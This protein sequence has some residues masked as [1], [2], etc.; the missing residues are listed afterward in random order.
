MR[1]QRHR[2]RYAYLNSAEVEA[3]AL[4]MLGKS[5]AVI[6]KV[7]GLSK[8]QISYRL[9]KAKNAD[10][11]PRGQGYRWQYRNQRPAASEVNPFKREVVSRLGAK[12]VHPVH[13]ASEKVAP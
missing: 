6:Q 9:H 4:A 1:S 10:G 2:V 8:C 3:V 13:F 12:F 11:L 5:D 7:T